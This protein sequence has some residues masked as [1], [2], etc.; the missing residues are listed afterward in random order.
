MTTDDHHLCTAQPRPAQTAT[1][2]KRIT[3]GLP[4][5][6][7]TSDRRFPLTPEGVDILV[8]QGFDIRIQSGAAD[9]IHYSDANY[10]RYGAEVTSRQ[11]ALQ[12][13]IVIHMAP[14]GASD[15]KMM[16]R[17]AMLLSILHPEQLVDYNVRALLDRRIISVAIDLIR[18]RQGNT[19]FYD[20]MM[21][22]DGRASMAIASTMLASPEHGKG[23]LLGGV[24][25]VNPCEVTILGSGIA[26]RAAAASA[27]GMGAIVN[28]FDNDIY[29]IRESSRLLGPGITVS[30]MHP[31]ILEKAL[32]GA[33]VVVATAQH[34]APQIGADLASVMKSGAI[35]MDL[36]YDES[37]SFPS[38]RAV[39]IS[40]SG[41]IP[42]GKSG[43]CCYINLGNAVP[44][45]A[46]MA[47]TNTFLSLMHEIIS[48]DGVT[49]TVKLL[50]GIQGAVFTFLGK[51]VN[52]R[53]AD[54]VKMRPMD[55]N[56]LL[57]CS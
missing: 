4:A 22:V 43:R 53:V 34:G 28:M 54:I 40:T 8:R 42:P 52:R 10:A 46:A 26:A 32:R 20:I 44:R 37:P 27:I 36:N 23:I 15:I 13:D 6:S 33:D 11:E 19:P 1:R 39:D 24:A 29:R 14:L 7:S 16:R 49:D 30:T 18:D 35:V 9:S 17:G 5:C 25:G 55:I 48:C 56:L 50:P 41:Q 3:L 38:L 2:K 21:E 31:R 57:N 45:T 47:L 51:P 12:S